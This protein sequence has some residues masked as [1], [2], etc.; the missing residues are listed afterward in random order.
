L[1]PGRR[2]RRPQDRRQ[3]RPRGP[4]GQR[5]AAQAPLPRLLRPG[6]R[7][8]RARQLHQGE[9]GGEGR[10][11]Q[12]HAGRLR[13]HRRHQ[14]GAGEA[15]PGDRLLRRHPRHRRQGRR[16]AGH[17]GGDQGRLEQGRQPLPGGDRQAGRPRVQSQG[18]RQE[19][20]GLHGWH[21]QA[22]QEVRFQEP[23]RQGSR[24][25]L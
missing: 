2:G 21:P 14:G 23:Q 20:A 19:L 15:L 8:L 12:P 13:R 7:R 5:A 1:V 10:Q 4:H 24:C 16:L 25:S 6:L 9:H 3:G 18:G 22:H 17:Q 11:A